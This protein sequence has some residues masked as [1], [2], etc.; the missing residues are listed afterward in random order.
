MASYRLRAADVTH[1]RLA[2]ADYRERPTGYRKHVPIET[3]DPAYISKWYTLTNPVGPALSREGRDSVNVSVSRTEDSAKIVTMRNDIS[4]PY[5]ELMSARKA[6]VPLMADHVKRVLANFHNKIG[7]MI[8]TGLDQPFTINGMT[9]DGTDLGGTLDTVYVATAGEFIDHADAWWSH[10]QTYKYTGPFTWIM[11]TSL[12]GY[13]KLPYLELKSQEAYMQETYNCTIDYEVGVATADFDASP[14]ANP[15][16]QIEWTADD[17]IWIVFDGKLEHM[18]LQETGPPSVYINPELN[19]KT[20]CFEGFVIW[21]GT[22]RTTNNT[23]I[24]YMEDVDSA[25]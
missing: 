5:T 2:A 10:M 23:A 11:S 25:A 21:Q 16:Y 8:Y 20:N 15:I 3:I 18:A 1:Y 9:E 7:Q 13:A 6:G 22:W 14:D 19:R 12:S 4:I 17:G 24:G